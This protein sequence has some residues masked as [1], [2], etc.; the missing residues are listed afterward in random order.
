MAV[1]SFITLAPGANFIK[2][3]WCDLRCHQRI[4]LSF[5]SGYAARG[6]NYKYLRYWTK[7][8]DDGDGEIFADIV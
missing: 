2:L 7:Y 1:K 6:I 5:D 8:L 3:F 4:A